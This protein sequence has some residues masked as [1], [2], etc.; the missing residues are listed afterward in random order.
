MQR[1]RPLGAAA[2]NHQEHGGHQKSPFPAARVGSSAPPAVKP[3]PGSHERASRS[4]EKEQ[5]AK[6]NNKVLGAAAMAS[7]LREC[8]TGGASTGYKLVDRYI[9]TRSAAKSNPAAGPPRSGKAENSSSRSS[10][11]IGEGEDP[12]SSQPRPWRWKEPDM[13]SAMMLM[14]STS[15]MCQTTKGAARDGK[16]GGAAS[17]AAAR[18]R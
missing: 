10:C 8:S 3:R 6:R 15:V 13:P 4:E 18:H 1:E 11:H 12:V 5:R 7:L 16:A 2:Y 14:E 9:V 17:P